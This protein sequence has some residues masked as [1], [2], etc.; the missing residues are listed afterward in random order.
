MQHFTSIYILVP[1]GLRDKLFI[2][3]YCQMKSHGPWKIK[4]TNEVYRDPFIH[5]WQDD[6]IR[7]DGQDGS[8]VVVSMKPGVC[9]L[10]ID[11]AL[12]VHLTDE[13][14]YGVGRHT[15][16][17][18]SGGIEPDEDPDI[19]ARR[20]LAEE[21]GIQA[22]KWEF[23][24]TVDPFTTIMISPTRLY[25]ATQLSDVPSNPD[26]TELIKRQ[27]IPLQSACEQIS[28]GQI[29]H[30]PTC[31]LILMAQQRFLN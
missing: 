28:N 1:V 8:H 6:V 25:F 30:A 21:L 18:V 26:G 20:E 24:T 10:A 11:E 7:P 23:L 15:L 29:T 4:K 16:E 2:S 12:N 22:A 31:N 5:V 19:T 13:F 3:T 27:V 17:A 9:V 14:H